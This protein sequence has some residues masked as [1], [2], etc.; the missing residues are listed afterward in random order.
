MNLFDPNRPKNNLGPMLVWQGRVVCNVPPLHVSPNDPAEGG[1]FCVQAYL[2]SGTSS[3][4]VYELDP[5]ESLDAIYAEYVADPEAF[6]RRLGFE[7]SAVP[8]AP[9]KAPMAIAPED[10]FDD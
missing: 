6:V 4:A 2:P 9:P 8:K 1:G 10:L 3:Y 7:L 5:V